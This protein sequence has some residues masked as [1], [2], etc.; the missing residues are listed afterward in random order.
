MDALVSLRGV[1]RWFG[2]EQVLA[3]VDLELP[4]GSVTA[5]LGRN[6]SGKSTLIRVIAGVLG[7][8]GGEASVL[9]RDP[10]ALAPPERERLAWVT[11]AS[12]SWAGARVA[13]EI[14]F[15]RRLWGRRWDEGRARALLARFEVPETKGIGALSKGQQTRL[16]LVLALAA[17][18]DLLLLDEP[19]LGLDLFARRDLLELMIEAVECEGRAILIASHLLDDVE[20]VADRIAFLREGRVCV[21]GEV[22]ALRERFRRARLALGAGGAGALA[23]AAADTLGVAGVRAEP[24]D[25]PEERVVVFTDFAAGADEALAA[26]AGARLVETRRMTLREIYFEVL[27][28][29]APP[30]PAAARGEAGGRGAVRIEGAEEE[31][32]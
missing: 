14:A 4:P 2:R 8:H 13:D 16:R 23:A 22:E 25:P 6:G 29:A 19:A 15:A 10:E 7:R 17:A 32:R 11:D 3:G 1:S 20:R 30:A 27:G 21:E 9:G 24:G 26:R 18:P 28:G 5:L 31:S 12:T